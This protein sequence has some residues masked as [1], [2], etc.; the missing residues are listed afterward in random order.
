[1]SVRTS[2]AFNWCFT[3]I[4][5]TPA[6]ELA[7]VNDLDYRYLVFQY[8]FTRT[9]QIHMQGYFVLAKKQRLSAI[10]KIIC[11]TIHLEIRR[12]T[13]EQARDYCKKDDTRACGPFEHGSE[14]GISCGR[15]ARTDLLEIKAKIDNGAT[16][17][18]IW[19]EHFSSSTRHHKAFDVYRDLF[20]QHRKFDLGEQPEI[21]VYWGPSGTGKS[22]RARAEY[23]EA[24]WLDQPNTKAGAV[25]W[26]GYEGEETIIIDEFYSWIPYHFLLRILDYY[27][28]SV[29]KKGNM[30]KLAAKRF[31]FTSNDNPLTW[32]NERTEHISLHRRFR[33]FGTIEHITQFSN[34][35]VPSSPEY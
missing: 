29:Q 10:K 22:H 8:E 25:W 19:Q 30:R 20:S 34:V 33:D 9:G 15:G 6:H 1:M 14:Q 27:P 2:L 32:F 24:F 31:V 5:P 18:I 17:E 3:L 23:P 26:D 4:D 12:G 11:K 13:H 16:K 28:V 21:I 7:L 35:V